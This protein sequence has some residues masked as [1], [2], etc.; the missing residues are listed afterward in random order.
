MSQESEQ[1]PTPADA[2]TLADV[3]AVFFLSAFW[4]MVVAYGLLYSQFLDGVVPEVGYLRRTLDPDRHDAVQ[5]TLGDLA[6]PGAA[7]LAEPELVRGIWTRFGLWAMVFAAPFQVV[8]CVLWFRWRYDSPV[9]A[10]GLTLAHWQRDL[11]L[12]LLAA[13]VLTPVILALHQLVVSLDAQLLQAPVEEHPLARLTRVELLPIEWVFLLGAAVLLAPLT[14]EILFRGV[15]QGY[16]TA[17]PL[18]G[19]GICGF[20][21]LLTY[22]RSHDAI[23][24]TRATAGLAHL[25]ALLPVLFAL[26]LG[27]GFVAVLHFAYDSPWPALYATAVLFA[28]I[29]PTW[30]QPIPLFVLGLGFGYL[31]LVTGSLLAPLLVHA[32]FNATSMALFLAGW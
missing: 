26:V 15:I 17:H 30:P 6:G 9:S 32:L 19:Y 11:G 21:V 10:L 31:R 24:A 25:D 4:Q 20:A 1:P 16:L 12:A 18:G 13:L 2:W 14:E 28:T 7:K 29:H 23:V 5:R 22:A 27:L 3:G 8:T